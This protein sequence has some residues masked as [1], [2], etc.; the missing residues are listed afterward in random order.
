MLPKDFKLPSTNSDNYLKLS[1][2]ETRIRILS[3]AIYGWKDWDGKNPIRF[4]VDM[5]PNK[6]IDPKRKIQYFMAYIVWDYAEEQVK[7][8]DITQVSIFTPI[9]KYFSDPEWG[10]AHHYDLKI[11]KK[12]AGMET[13]Y[14]V[15]PCPQKPINDKIIEAFKKRPCNLQV[16]FD[17]G[18]PFS[19]NL[20]NFTPS[21]WPMN[22]PSVFDAPIKSGINKDAADKL[23]IILEQCAPDYKESVWQALHKNK[24]TSLTELSSEM[25]NRI[26]AAAQKKAD[27]NSNQELPF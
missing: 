15:I 24:I 16:L 5:K 11:I 7:V 18:H 20:E 21:L 26:L 25:Y 8:F 9:V 1:D 4:R 12:G 22:N 13:E 10:S 23:A 19:D 2:G 14:D 3:E 17:A 6:P 27:E